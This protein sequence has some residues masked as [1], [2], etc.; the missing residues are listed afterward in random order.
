MIFKDKKR[1]QVKN[2]TPWQIANT[3]YLN[4]ATARST[5]SKDENTLIN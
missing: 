1:D 5:V 3:A 4:D 2:P